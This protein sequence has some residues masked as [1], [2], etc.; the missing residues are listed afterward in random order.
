MACGAAVTSSVWVS[1]NTRTATLSGSPALPHPDAPICSVSD[2]TCA[3]KKRRVRCCD[4]LACGA[5]PSTASTTRL[6]GRTTCEVWECV[7]WWGGAAVVCGAKSTGSHPGMWMWV[8]G[9]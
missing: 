2:A 1:N 3:D 4:I 6:V 7:R 9:T 8:R 5:T